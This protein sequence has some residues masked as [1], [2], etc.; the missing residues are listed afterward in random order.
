MKWIG[1]ATAYL[2]PVLLLLPS[3]ILHFSSIEPF[4]RGYFCLDRSIQYPFV[5]YQTVP[6][7]LCAVIWLLFCIGHLSFD[8]ISKKSWKQ[9]HETVYKLILGFS[10][11]MLVTDVSKFSIGRL[12]PYFMTVCKPDMDNVCYDMN[13]SN[14]VQEDNETYYFP[15]VH[16]QR[17]VMAED[18]CSNL[19]SDKS[20]LK[21]ARLSFVSGHSSSSFYTAVYLVLVTGAQGGTASATS[22]PWIMKILLQLSSI[23]MAFWISLTRISDYMHHPED[24]IMGAIIGTLCAFFMHRFHPYKDRLHA[25]SS[26][27]SSSN[28]CD[29]AKHL[30]EE[31]PLA[32][33]QL[34]EGI[35]T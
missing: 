29:E 30:K 1:Y 12:R 31:T 11:C 17:Y 19:T 18:T 4:H 24:V 13:I 7:Y 14:F 5:E 33:I 32:N 21:E 3:I 6:S 2:I 16:H 23:L 28:N 9:L 22:S 26:S 15:D 25:S 10:I 20:L 35:G 34:K 8:F 27:S